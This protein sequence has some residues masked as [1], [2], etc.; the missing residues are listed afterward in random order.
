MLQKYL[1]PR[2]IV[3]H[4]VVLLIA[5]VFLRLGVWQLDRLAERRAL[6]ATI[7]ARMSLPP[8]G[9]GEILAD[10]L[11]E[12]AEYR[13]VVAAGSYDID[14]EILI[15]SC[16]NNGEAGFHVVTPLV[17]EDGVTVLVNRGWVPLEFDQ[18]PVGSA[19]PPAER[20]QVTGT[21]RGSQ[22][23][24]SLG[25]RDPSDGD[26]ERMYWVDIPRIQQQSPHTLAPVYLELV[27]QVPG[28]AGS[29]PVPVPAGELSEGSHLAYALQWFAFTLIGLVGYTALLRRSKPRRGGVGECAGD[30]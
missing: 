21:I 25:P 30:L 17:T 16:T 11:P 9:L 24:P 23:A 1:T 28:Q 26:L 7:S 3:A 13:P 27:S 6:N 20:T 4:L 14:G 8:E 19:L 22:V 12:E 2:W 10:T 29:L 15:R 18:P 5:G